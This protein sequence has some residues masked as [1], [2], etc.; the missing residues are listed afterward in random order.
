MTALRILI[1]YCRYRE[2][3]GEDTVVAAQAELLKK[4]GHRVRL[5][6]RDNQDVNHMSRAQLACESI[7]IRTHL[8]RHVERARCRFRPNIVTC[9]TPSR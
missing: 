8:S 6:E 1:A 3:G 4:R 7:W 9:I 2:R 5:Y